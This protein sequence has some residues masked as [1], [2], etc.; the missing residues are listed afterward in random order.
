MTGQQ[1]GVIAVYAAIAELAGSDKNCLAGH[2]IG[3]VGATW[4]AKPV[5]TTL[6]TGS[7]AQSSR[8]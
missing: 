1:T 3:G 2:G 6:G 7:A 8:R 5:F 4:A